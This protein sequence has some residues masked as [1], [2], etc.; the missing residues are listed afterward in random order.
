[1]R[2]PDAAL[3]DLEGTIRDLE[4]ENNKLSKQLISIK[5]QLR[6]IEE[7]RLTVEYSGSNWEIRDNEIVIASDS[8]LLGAIDRL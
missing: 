3:F 5:N 4:Y 7:K 1:M 6:E 8:R 2:N